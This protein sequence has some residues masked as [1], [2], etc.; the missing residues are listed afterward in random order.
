MA[1]ETHDSCGSQDSHHLKHNAHIKARGASSGMADVQRNY[2]PSAIWLLYS[3]HTVTVPL[4]GTGDVSY[5]CGVQAV[6]IQL[7]PFKQTCS[8]VQ[9]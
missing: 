4:E 1:V 6:P 8:L 3:E 2:K 9:A 7:R 5:F